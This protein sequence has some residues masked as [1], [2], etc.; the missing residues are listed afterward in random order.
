MS[1]EQRETSFAV[2]LTPDFNEDGTW[3]GVVGCHIEEEITNDL[4]EDEI[5][6]IRTV[7]GLLATTLT[8]M[9]QDEDF[10]EYIKEA[11]AS[12]NSEMLQEFVGAVED[13]K[14]NFTKDGNVIT[15]DFDTKTHGSA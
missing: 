7:C 1:D 2:V 15:L 5:L 3:N 12:L 11:F 8:V 4:S 6:Q 14:P 13:N 10:L 9:E